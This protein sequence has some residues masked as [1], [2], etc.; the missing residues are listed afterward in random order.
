MRNW[1][2]A[3]LTSLGS[4]LEYYDFVTYIMLASFISEIF[5][6]ATDKHIDFI[7]TLGIF[8]SAYVI[9]PLGGIVFGHF[10]DRYG[11]KKSLLNSILLM[12]VSTVAIGLL[13]TYKTAGLISPV[14][15]MTFRL[16]QGLSQGAEIPG[17][18]TFLTEHANAQKRGKYIGML[19]SGITLGAILSTYINLLLTQ[20]FTHHE[21]INYA[22]RLPFL[23]GGILALIAYVLRQKVAETYLFSS[24]PPVNYWPIKEVMR[25]HKLAILRG[26][27]IVL[28]PACMII[29]AL[30][31]PAYLMKYLNYP[32][33]EVYSAMTLS[34]I[35]SAL[36]LLVFG[37]LSDYIGR[38]L[39]MLLASFIAI[40]FLSSLF[41][42]LLLKNYHCI[43]SFMILY[44]TLLSC[45]AAAYPSMLAEFFVTKI[46]YTG[47]AISYNF[48][49]ILAAFFPMLLSI[50]STAKNHEYLAAMLLCGLSVFCFFILLFTSD[51]TGKSLI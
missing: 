7:L 16:F 39:L 40:V 14:L 32:A 17:A 10:A 5:F 36:M 37:Y 26:I 34:L 25:N 23:F 35:W 20:H 38:K 44:Q 3:L 21:I 42:L 8:A 31:L 41:K 48:S 43:L 9:R 6:P 12:A 19:M 18:I 2:I 15:L 49:F 33:A 51:R 47:V 1:K 11:R 29:F 24:Q 46:R 27:S 45:F 4:G 30:F 28:L 50:Y 22:W 13:P